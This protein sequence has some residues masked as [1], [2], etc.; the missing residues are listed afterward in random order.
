MPL[1]LKIYSTIM[2]ETL[3]PQTP[4]QTVGPYFAYGLVPQQYGYNF[5]SLAGNDLTKG[6]EGSKTITLTGKVYDGNEQPMEDAM[7]ELWLDDGENRLFGRYG[8]GTEE[9]KSFVFKA[10][11]PKS[12]KGQ[13]PY[14]SVI[15]F[16]RGQLLHS[17]TRIYFEDEADLNETDEVL[18][19]VS[20][21]RRPTLIAK[22][23]GD[24]Y[25]FDIHMQGPLETVFFQL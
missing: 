2:T 17:Y 15:L 6:L 19:A 12:V 9:D 8:T 21:E 1:H 22:K 16:M 23:K 5:E 3:K 20:S 18:K 4:S 24:G 13:A 7:I 10:V 11:K 25:E 14:I